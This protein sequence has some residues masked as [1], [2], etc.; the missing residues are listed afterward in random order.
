M[1]KGV[2]AR[3][4]CPGFGWIVES[5]PC[6]LAFIYRHTAGERTG[7]IHVDALRA[8]SRGLSLPASGPFVLHNYFA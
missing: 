3:I 1:V 2:R 5:D 6:K 7:G 8:F 4:F